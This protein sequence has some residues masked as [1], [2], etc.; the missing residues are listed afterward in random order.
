M[1][2]S[3]GS[4]TGGSAAGEQAGKRG[5]IT[6][7]IL[8]M[9]ERRKTSRK[10]D[11]GRVLVIGGST[12]F[13]GA[14]T[15]AAAA[16]KGVLR[17]GADIAILAAPA[18]VA[19]A[20]NAICSD[21]ITKKLSGGHI[22][23]KHSKELTEEAGKADVVLIGC[24]IGRK[25]ST[26]DLVRSLVKRLSKKGKLMVLDADALKAVRLQDVKNSILTPH[27]KEFEAILKNSGIKDEKEARKKLGSNVLLIKGDKDRIISK[28]KTAYNKTGNPVMTK[29]GTGDVLAGL[30]AGFLT[31][32]KDPFRSACMA[33]YLNG[34]VGDYLKKRKGKTFIASDIVDNIHKVLK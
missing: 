26:M 22:S 34:A 30:C 5:Y 33:A 2:E 24:G 16:A 14:P 31:Q 19:W 3:I 28:D 21:I 15:L 6:R 25:K 7:S 27:E 11:F 1:G 29:G 4:G 20:V 8:R 12:D 32:T 23:G 18:G 13:A 9:P 10:G 17:S